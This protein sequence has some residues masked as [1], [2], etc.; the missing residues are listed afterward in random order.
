[1]AYLLSSTSARG[2]LV[3]GVLS[4]QDMNDDDI[5]SMTVSVK[6]NK[7]RKLEEQQNSKLKKTDEF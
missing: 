4:F 3:W 5:N 2:G 7:L 6:S 1:L